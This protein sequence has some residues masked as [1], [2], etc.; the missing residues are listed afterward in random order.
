MSDIATRHK[1][2]GYLLGSY[3]GLFAEARI[4][5]QLLP[6]IQV[7]RSLEKERCDGVLVI[8]DVSRDPQWPHRPH[9]LAERQFLPLTHPERLE[10]LKGLNFD[11][12][13]M[14]KTVSGRRVT[15]S[16][17]SS[18]N[19]RDATDFYVVCFG[20]LP[21]MCAIVPKEYLFPERR[22][23][24]NLDKQAMNHGITWNR[25]SPRVRQQIDCVDSNLAENVPPA[26]LPFLVP[27]NI[28]ILVMDDI[29][30]AA[31]MK[32]PFTNRFTEVEYSRWN[33][34]PT[35]IRSTVPATQV[36]SYQRINTIRIELEGPN[37]P[38]FMELMVRERC[39]PVQEFTNI[40][41]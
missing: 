28:L 15:W 40:P 30:E 3:A 19:Q 37:S 34:E 18:P 29:R 10:R 25:S 5:E 39:P 2:I 13:T 1:L 6:Y 7:I 35:P 36:S 27:A 20:R 38:V 8:D 12:K 23:V 16:F 31:K 22:E 9:Q 14:D 26:L 17:D 32:K 21:N 33:L 4:F 41:S 24:S 11:V